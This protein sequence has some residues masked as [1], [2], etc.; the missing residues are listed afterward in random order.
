V[1][2][3]TTLDYLQQQYGLLGKGAV[4]NY[5]DAAT[6]F[7][8]LYKYVGVRA[9][10]T[11]QVVARCRAIQALLCREHVR[12]VCIGGG[13]GTELIGLAKHA[14]V[15]RHRATIAACIIDKEPAW[16]A[17]W[18]LVSKHMSHYLH[19]HPAIT[20]ALLELDATAPT[21]WATLDRHLCADLYTMSY[22]LS[23]FR[24]RHASAARFLQSVL[25][26]AKPGA[27]FVFLDLDYSAEYEWFEGLATSHGLEQVDPDL[28]SRDLKLSSDEDPSYLNAM[29]KRF[30]DRHSPHVNVHASHRVYCKF[31][32]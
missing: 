5:A 31:A 17:S 10:F 16:R 23:E 12:V 9:D 26:G 1:A 21:T 13:P 3:R 24:N 30:N 2:I 28:D 18:E 32:A 20:G 14:S 11:Y 29:L 15:Y 4:I 7:A 19:D 25:R 6:R 22:F 27:L 8:Y